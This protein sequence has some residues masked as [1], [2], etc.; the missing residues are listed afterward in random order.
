VADAVATL[1]AEGRRPAGARR[2]SAHRIASRL[3]E[4]AEGVRS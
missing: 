1:L 3:I 4:L 2:R